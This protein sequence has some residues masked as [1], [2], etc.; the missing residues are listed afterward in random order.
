MSYPQG[1]YQSDR[2]QGQYGYSPYGTVAAGDTRDRFLVRTYNHLFGA[3]L[4]FAGIEI[5]L[6]KTGIADRIV[7]A[8]AGNWLIAIMLFML[9]GWG[10]THAAHRAMSKAAQYA[11][12]AGFVAMQ[13]IMFVPL[14]WMANRFAPGAIQSA[15]LV[16]IL[17]FGALTGIVFWTR[18]DFSFL[19][20]FLRWA[21]IAAA[22][23]IVASLIFGF[24]LGVLFSVAMVGLAGAAILYDTSNV[25]H[26]YPEDRYVG[27]AL[28]LFSSVALLFWYVLRLF[29]SSRD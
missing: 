11:A 15:G 29:M 17:G 19:G 13:A 28:E 4:L 21:F 14:L 9:V 2:P 24:S 10:A 18:K 22:L 23:V 3:I 6:F 7:G 1:R 27:A 8:L 16:T 12:L 20:A 26:H 25:L 5:A